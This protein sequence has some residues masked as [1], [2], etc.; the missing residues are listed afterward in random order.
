V[1]SIN[2]F[3]EVYFYM[4]LT[5]RP[6]PK[7]SPGSL[8]MR[9][10]FERGLIMFARAHN[11]GIRTVS[12]EDPTIGFCP[13]FEEGE[14]NQ[15][16]V[17]VGRGR[18]FKEALHKALFLFHE[19]NEPVKQSLFSQNYPEEIHQVMEKLD[20]WLVSRQGL[21]R[22]VGDFDGQILVRIE[23]VSCLNDKRMQ[24]V[25]SEGAGQTFFAALTDALV[26]P[27]YNPI[28]HLAPQPVEVPEESDKKPIVAQII[29]TIGSGVSAPK[30]YTKNLKIENRSRLF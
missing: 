18:N 26:K 14:P 19:V 3:V 11:D 9:P 29:E 8:P 13:D 10:V 12:F 23:G 24:S 28:Q 5:L 16:I 17:Y 22:A 20:K 25:V 4:N 21:L 15:S 2:C 1:H 7:Q 6:Q 30:L 27:L